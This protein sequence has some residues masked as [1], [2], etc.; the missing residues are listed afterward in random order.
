[1]QIFLLDNPIKIILP[2]RAQ[3]RAAQ[4]MHKAYNRVWM[5]PHIRSDQRRMIQLVL[6]QDVQTLRQSK[7]EV[8][9]QMRTVIPPGQGD[10]LYDIALCAQILN[11]L[12]VIQ[13][14]A[15]DS[16]QRPVNNKSDFH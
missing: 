9:H 1:M 16:I 5:S 13:I 15:A 12:A 10:D 7:A 6:N 11:Q 14:S 2:L 8:I 4:M 3:L